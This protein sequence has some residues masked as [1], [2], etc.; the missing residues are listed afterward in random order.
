MWAWG[1]NGSGQLGDNT[2]TS[3]STIA[4]VT[5]L[6]SVTAI[7]AGAYFS[8]ARK[9]DGT[10]WTWGL[11]NTGQLGDGTVTQRSVPTQVPAL[12]GVVAIAAGD[13]HTVVRTT[14]GA[15]WAKGSNAEGQLGDGTSTQRTSPVL[16]PGLTATAGPWAGS[17]YTL[18]ATGDGGL[19]T[20]G[21][22][23]SGQLGIGTTAGPHRSPTLVA[24][25]SSPVVADGGSGAS[26][27]V[28]A[29][30]SVWAWGGNYAGEVGD[31]TLI[32]RPS[33]VLIAAVPNLIA[34]AA[35]NNF[36]VGV[37]ADGAV[38][39]WGGNA[40][41]QLGD[42]TLDRRLVPVPMSDPGFT[43]KT[44]TPRLSPSS[45]AYGAVT[46]VTVTAV[47]AG[48]Q[49]HYATTG[50]DPTESDPSVASGGT[51]V[52]DQSM[53]LKARAWRS[54]MPASNVA[55]AT[56]TMTLPTPA[57]TPAAG[58][59]VAA[60]TVTLSSSVAGATIR[61]TIDGTAP[62]AASSAYTAPFTVDAIT[63]VQAKAFKSG[64][65]D[66]GVV[67]S[68]YALKVVTPAF[69]PARGSYAPPQAIALS[70]TTPSATI[71]STTDGHE[72]TALSPVYTAPI[73]LSVTSTVKATARAP[74]GSTATAARRV[75]GSR[76]G[77][78]RCRRCSRR[79]APIP[80]RSTFG[81][82]R[83]RAAPSCAIRSM[84]RTRY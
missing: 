11:N 53:T 52:V 9:S 48:A 47:T 29:D 64:W 54:G 63:T 1:N 46:S 17:G 23:G 3:R 12:S 15:I 22:N 62:T 39:V 71:R 10:V 79:R 30:G 59:Y 49:I 66:S 20:W 76:R 68:T 58:T 36:T 41:G 42:G 32:T 14:S 55:A 67:T 69:S 51:V 81:W 57:M 8:V 37:T 34:V 43:W 6:S 45:A 5:G 28:T 74:D 50:A 25:V 65:T 18:A 61:F 75:I 82:R 21:F 26:V 24:L 83:R 19:W 2:T 4:P 13:F 80:R 70:T 56:Y 72:P 73:T 7:A 60:Q 44:S 16:V 33:P 84:G 40:S 38:W 31:G 35:D 77:P 78:R 27:A